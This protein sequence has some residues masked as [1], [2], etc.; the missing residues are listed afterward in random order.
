[1]GSLK[2]PKALLT[3]WD[4]KLKDSGFVDCEKEKEKKLNTASFKKE[5]EISREIRLEYYLEVGSHLNSLLPTD[6]FSL[7][8]YCNEL[9]MHLHSEGLLISEIVRRLEFLGLP[10]ERKTVRYIIRRHQK[11]WGIRNWNLKQLRLKKAT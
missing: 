5:H 11:E 2:I 3:E 10:K 8:N 1:M 7:F 6:Q 9:I 4:Q